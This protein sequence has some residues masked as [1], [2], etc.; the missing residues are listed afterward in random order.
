M[1]GEFSSNCR[2]MP[3]SSSLSAASHQSLSHTHYS[4]AVLVLA[5]S[6]LYQK[7]WIVNIMSLNADPC[8]VITQ[9]F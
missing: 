7:L 6:K 5:A 8:D 9:S 3:N 4:A 2:E 1:G